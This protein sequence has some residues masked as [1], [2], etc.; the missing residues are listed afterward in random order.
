MEVQEGARYHPPFP[1]PPPPPCLEI[2]F[3]GRY[4]GIFGPDYIISAFPSWGARSPSALA[5]N[6]VPRYVTTGDESKMNRRRKSRR[7]RGDIDRKLHRR[8]YARALDGAFTSSAVAY[9]RPHGDKVARRCRPALML[10]MRNHV[11]DTRS[12]EAFMCDV[13]RN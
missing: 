10:M 12:A 13:A 2:P 4:A 7:P 3:R 6:F 11:L 8:I 1:P 9:C 5:G